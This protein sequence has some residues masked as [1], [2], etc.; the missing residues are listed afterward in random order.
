MGQ[1]YTLLTTVGNYKSGK[2]LSSYEMDLK[3]MRD[4][5]TGGR[6]FDK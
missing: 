1:Y 3:L 6:K 4:A 5:L 2:N